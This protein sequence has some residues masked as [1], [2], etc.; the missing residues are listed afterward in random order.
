MIELSSFDFEHFYQLVVLIEYFSNFLDRFVSR[1][2]SI[3][4]W[5]IRIFVGHKSK[6]FKYLLPIS[7]NQGNRELL[8][9]SSQQ[10]SI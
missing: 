5:E 10:I 8:Y 1:S 9:G 4:P 3:F 6:N 2:R 7:L